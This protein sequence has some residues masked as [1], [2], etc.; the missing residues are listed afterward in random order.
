MST[1]LGFVGAVAVAA[2]PWTVIAWCRLAPFA[3]A[4]ALVDATVHRLPD[5]L[6]PVAGVGLIVILAGVAAPRARPG[7]FVRALVA[8]LVLGA[9][10]PA[11][12]LVGGL[13]MGD[14]K[15]VPVVGVALGWAGWSCVL[16][17]ACA[18]FVLSGVYAGAMLV[19]RRGGRAARV[20]FGPFMIAAACV[21][22]AIGG[23]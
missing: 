13:G 4:L 16:V 9:F 20:P 1:G 11:P 18:A 15:L 21:A 6:V 3:V 22:L 23:T 5:R 7:A 19:V 12:A 17:G 10:H 14:V 8:G 2:P